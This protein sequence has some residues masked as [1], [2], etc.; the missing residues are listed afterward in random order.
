[1]F[2]FLHPVS[3]ASTTPDRNKRD[4]AAHFNARLLRMRED[5]QRDQTSLNTTETI[6]M[7]I[8]ALILFLEDTLYGENPNQPVNRAATLSSWSRGHSM[9]DN[10]PQNTAMQ[11]RIATN[12]YA[13]TAQP[14]TQKHAGNS[15]NPPTAI[16]DTYDLIHDLRTLRQRGI[17]HVNAEKYPALMAHVTRIMNG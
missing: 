1:M 9:N 3:G 2:T 12:A 17:T 10:A 7:S 16:D 8:D 15:N 13:N 14:Y 6:S 5:S 11:N 4:S